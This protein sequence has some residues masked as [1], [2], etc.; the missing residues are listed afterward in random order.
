MYYHPLYHV[1]SSPSTFR[2]KDSLGLKPRYTRGRLLTIGRPANWSIKFCFD[3]VFPNCILILRSYRWGK[4]CPCRNINVSSWGSRQGFLS[5]YYHLF[6]LHPN[7][8]YFPKVCICAALDV[9]I[10][11]YWNG[12][13]LELLKMLFGVYM[14]IIIF[15]DCYEFC[16]INLLLLN[17]VACILSLLTEA[18]APIPSREHL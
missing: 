11:M 13:W 12:V 18:W 17:S 8:F 3:L 2:K 9:G 6:F 15:F 4:Q 1:T 7:C 10:F 5:N 16:Y 14:F